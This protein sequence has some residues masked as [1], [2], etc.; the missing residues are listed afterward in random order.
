MTNQTSNDVA[1]FLRNEHDED[2]RNWSQGEVIA[3]LNSLAIPECT[4][5]VHRADRHNPKSVIQ[6]IT[7]EC[8]GPLSYESITQIAGL[9]E[10]PHITFAPA[11]RFPDAAGSNPAEF[12]LEYAEPFT[13][14]VVRWEAPVPVSKL[15]SRFEELKSALDRATAADKAQAIADALNGPGGYEDMLP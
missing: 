13:S 3:G 6:A 7:L 4:L 11:V 1:E 2:P 10:T 5:H 9:F 14:I 12:S 8:A 15:P